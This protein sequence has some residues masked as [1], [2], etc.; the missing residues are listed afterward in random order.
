M[1]DILYLNCLIGYPPMVFCEL[2]ISLNH[3]GSARKGCHRMESKLNPASFPPDTQVLII[4]FLLRLYLTIHCGK[5]NEKW[6][7]CLQID[8]WNI[9]LTKGHSLSLILIIQVDCVVETHVARYWNSHRQTAGK[10]CL[11][12][13]KLQTTEFRQQTCEIRPNPSLMEPKKE[14]STLSKILFEVL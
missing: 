12:S 14:T 7:P 2:L 5:G 1:R 3:C 4:V 10:W 6:C 11:Q 9:I 8:L 13:K